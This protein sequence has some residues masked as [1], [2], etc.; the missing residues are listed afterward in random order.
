[1]HLTELSWVDPQRCAGV[2]ES[3]VQ[4]TKL[5]EHVLMVL[6]NRGT[7]ATT[8]GASSEGLGSVSKHCVRNVPYATIIVPSTP[9]GESGE[10]DG[11]EGDTA[12]KVD[13]PTRVCICVDGSEISAVVL[14]FVARHFSSASGVELHLVC[15]AAAQQLPVRMPLP[16][17]ATMAAC[18]A[19]HPPIHA[20]VGGPTVVQG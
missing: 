18:A 6:S 17:D 7:G 16:C 14:S 20:C 2:A 1:M 12:M 4:H 5:K 3:L 13:S 8:G 11:P 15:V 10:A 9:A 19:G